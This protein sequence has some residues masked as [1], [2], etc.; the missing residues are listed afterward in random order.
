MATTKPEAPATPPAPP[1]APQTVANPSAGGSYL[2][3]PVTGV[4]TLD[5]PPA[6]QE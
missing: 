5:I 6:T 1:P 2:R 4:L 3:D